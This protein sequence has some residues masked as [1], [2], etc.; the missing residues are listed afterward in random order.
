M[1]FASGNHSPMNW[2][3]LLLTLNSQL[4]IGTIVP[5]IASVTAALILFV[6]ALAL[7][8]AGRFV[9]RIIALFG[10]GLV[11][12][13][14]SATIGGLVLGIVGFVIGGL[15][16]FIV[17]ALASFVLLPLAIGFATAIIAYN[18]TQSLVHIFPLS[19]LAGVVV[20]IIAI[21]ASMKLL[22][23]ATVVFG[24]LILINVLV[25][26]HFPAI[27]STLSA[28]LIGVVGF[29]IQGG[30]ENRQRAKFAS[31]TR[32]PPPPNAVPLNSSPSKPG[33]DHCP[34]CGT[35]IE[36]AGAQFCPNCGTSLNS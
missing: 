27:L 35:K 11:F 6:V 19:I 10:V 22:S 12:A 20:F 28:V 16:G 24:S 2:I 7:I 30:F 33:A 36:N 29:W 5:R 25:F 26:F 34:R 23:L 14:A 32:N 18:L 4:A 21:L 13:A 31:W 17:G 3:F 15:F 1:Q 8:F 9:I